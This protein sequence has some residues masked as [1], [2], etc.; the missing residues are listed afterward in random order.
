VKKGSVKPS[1]KKIPHTK[2]VGIHY[3]LSPGEKIKVRGEEGVLKS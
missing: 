2:A 1:M 3:I